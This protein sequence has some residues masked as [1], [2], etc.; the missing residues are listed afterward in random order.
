MKH[1]ALALLLLPSIASAADEPPTRIEMPGYKNPKFCDDKE[2]KLCVMYI[3]AGEPAPFDGMLYTVKQAAVQT[4]K[5]EEARELV[6]VE[7]EHQ[8][9]LDAVELAKEKALH[10]IDLDAGEDSKKKMKELY[11]KQ[12]DLVEPS[13]YEEP[14]V[15]IPLTVVVTLGAVAG[16]V[17][18]YDKIRSAP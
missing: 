4:A 18:I 8:K 7:V 2:M 10:Q 11:E 1:L 16:S 6:T 5:L 12:L 13:W 15:V 17:L 14:I 9:K 3:K